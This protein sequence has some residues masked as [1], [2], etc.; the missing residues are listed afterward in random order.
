MVCGTMKP[1]PLLT[2]GHGLLD[3]ATLGELLRSSGVQAV[4]DV[5]IHPTS[6]RNPD[7]RRER[8]ER[9][10]PAVGIDYRWERRLGGR[11]GS[12]E[13][14]ADLGLPEALR[15]YAAH[16]RGDDF[17]AAL[18]RL[19][20]ESDEQRTA[21]M[22]AEGDPMRC[23]RSVI[24]DLVVLIGVRDVVHVRHDGTVE[25]HRPRPSA[26]VE[27]GVVHYDRGT[28]PPLPGT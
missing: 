5:R 27:D 23:H 28:S 4:V 24:A 12:P 9:W 7:A 13:G 19:L 21:I 26:R 18:D 8:L 6:R 15:A 20:A 14:G 1:E 10:L 17:R 16:A 3:A 11:R 2:V 22:C 25:P